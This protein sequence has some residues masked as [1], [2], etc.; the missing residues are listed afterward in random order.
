MYDVQP[1]ACLCQYQH[2]HIKHA[3]TLVFTV[4]DSLALAPNLTGSHRRNLQILPKAGVLMLKTPRAQISRLWHCH[5]TH[6]TIDSGAAACAEHR[7][8]ADL[9]NIGEALVHEEAVVAPVT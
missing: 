2:S 3:G 4:S 9:Q 6:P 1:P 5:H 7:T 8:A